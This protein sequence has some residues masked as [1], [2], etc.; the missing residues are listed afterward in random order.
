MKK[1][2]CGRESS[3]VIVELCKTS[4]PKLPDICD[5]DIDKDPPD[6]RVPFNG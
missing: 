1:A 5:S 4:S 2:E 6:E 3:S